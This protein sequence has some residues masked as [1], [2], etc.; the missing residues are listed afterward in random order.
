MDASVNMVLMRDDGMAAGMIDKSWSFNEGRR[1]H[2]EKASKVGVT[3]LSVLYGK[4]E[5]KGLEQWTPLPTEGKAYTIKAT[6]GGLQVADQDGKAISSEERSVV[7]REYGYVGKPHPLLIMLARGKDGAEQNLSREAITSIAGF[8]PEMEVESMRARLT[9][10]D[11]KGDREVSKVDLVL[12]GVL[13]NNETKLALD[14]KGPASIDTKSGWVVELALEGN[15]NVS[16]HYVHKDKKLKASGKGKIKL[17][18]NT[19]IL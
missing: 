6:G 15:I 9:G 11:K 18:R 8:M 10:T 5:G 14:L 13:T 16:G 19:K 17:G 12:A 2:I 4:R 3:V 7:E 1:S